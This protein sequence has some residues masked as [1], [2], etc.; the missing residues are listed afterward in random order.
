MKKEI[1]RR[2]TGLFTLRPH[3]VAARFAF[4]RNALIRAGIYP[5]L[6]FIAGR[7]PRQIF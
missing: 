7:I 5:I 6:R 1:Q 4:L 2:I 3:L